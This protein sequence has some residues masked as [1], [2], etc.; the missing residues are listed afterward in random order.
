M[1]RETA[2]TA[3]PCSLAE[4][5]AA[6]EE[7]VATGK[8]TKAQAALID[9]REP[10]AQERAYAETLVPRAHAALARSAKKAAA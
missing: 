1:P 9:L 4:R 6:L 2:L 8:I 7:L 5:K 3:K 10:T